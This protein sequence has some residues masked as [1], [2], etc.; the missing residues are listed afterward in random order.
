MAN[1]LSPPPPPDRGSEVLVSAV[2]AGHTHPPSPGRRGEKMRYLP[3][4]STPAHGS[5]EPVLPRWS[6]PAQG[7]PE[8]VLPRDLAHLKACG[9]TGV[10]SMTTRGS[11]GPETAGQHNVTSDTQELTPRGPERRDLQKTTRSI[12]QHGASRKRKYFILLKRHNHSPVVQRIP[13]PSLP[14]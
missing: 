8:P 9:V 11:D 2:S 14:S 5:P 7:S 1:T 13:S 12:E 4:W 3:R 10:V 6:T